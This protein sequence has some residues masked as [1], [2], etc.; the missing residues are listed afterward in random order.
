MLSQVFLC[1]W[2]TDINNNTL[3]GHTAHRE[4]DMG[5]TAERGERERGR[6]R[7][8]RER[9]RDRQTDREIELG[10]IILQGLYQLYLTVT[11]VS[12]LILTVTVSVNLDLLYQSVDLTAT[13]V[14]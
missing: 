11:I 8:E 5:E 1:V 3:R 7:G 13:I 12:Q 14:I 4:R 2:Q 6:E 10:N 9:G